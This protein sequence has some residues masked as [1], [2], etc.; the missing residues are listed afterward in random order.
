MGCVERDMAGVVD[1]AQVQPVVTPAAPMAS[2]AGSADA[3]DMEA[4]M[5]KFLLQVDKVQKTSRKPV[6]Y[7][8]LLPTAMRIVQD[9]P[10]LS[11]GDKRKLALSLLKKL[12]ER[13]NPPEKDTI[14]AALDFLGPSMV[15]TL[16]SE[17]PD[18]GEIKKWCFSCCKKKKTPK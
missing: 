2:V 7:V 17:M 5:A 13:V 10:N 9:L 3:I 15:N 12:V 4:L 14:L 16:F 18:V 11:G 6:H 1:P 8:N